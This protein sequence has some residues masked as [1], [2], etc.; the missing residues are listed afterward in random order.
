M[1]KTCSKLNWFI[2]AALTFLTAFTAQAVNIT[3]NGSTP[4]GAGCPVG[5]YSITWA[6]DMTSFS[7]LF[8]QMQT[9]IP[10]QVGR[11]SQTTHCGMLLNLVLPPNTQISIERIDYRG[12]YALDA[13]AFWMINSRYFFDNGAAIYKANGAIQPPTTFVGGIRANQ[14]GP[15]Q[16]VFNWGASTESFAANVSPCGGPTNLAIVTNQNI[17]SST[18]P[19]A[20]QATLDSADSAMSVVYKLN[21][22]N[23]RY[24]FKPYPVNQSAVQSLLKSTS[25]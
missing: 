18:Q 17:S 1:K 8:D 15:V 6:P 5:T 23:C 11:E 25:L 16:D 14:A 24:K 19:A 3:F 7:I 9:A 12:F 10:G 2:A 13:G 20:G 4:N 22:T 21:V